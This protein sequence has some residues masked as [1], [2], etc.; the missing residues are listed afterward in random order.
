MTV[1]H[2]GPEHQKSK[3]GSG[4]VGII[5]SRQAARD[6]KEN[7]EKVVEGGDDINGT[8]TFLVVFLETIKT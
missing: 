7:G 8:T 4:G 1:V 6:W 3:R 2:H 5:I